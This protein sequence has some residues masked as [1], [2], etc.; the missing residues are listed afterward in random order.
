MAA[1]GTP[2]AM[3]IGGKM[4]SGPPKG[5]YAVEVKDATCDVSKKKGTPFVELEL[6]VKNDEH[7]PD[8][9]GK[10]LLKQR[11]YGPNPETPASDQE[12]AR[13]RLN[14]NLLKP[15]GMKW[16]TE[17]KPLEPRQ[18]IGKSFFV[19]LDHEGKPQD[20][21]DPRI[22]VKRIASKREDLEK[23]L[24]GVIAKANAEGEVKTEKPKTSRAR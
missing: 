21:N 3:K 5:I 20:P 6:F 24:E 14:R 17:E 10:R 22:E 11:F 18:F 8:R 23:A 7:N 15:L 4:S 16:P 12:A 19:L 1:I 2:A 9:N 13:G